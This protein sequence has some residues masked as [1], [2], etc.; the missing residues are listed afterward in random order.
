MVSSYNAWSKT[1]TKL[2]KFGSLGTVGIDPTNTLDAIADAQ[3]KVA[4]SKLKTDIF[5]CLFS[6]NDHV[7][8]EN[9]FFFKGDER[10]FES[11]FLSLGM[12]TSQMRELANSGVCGDLAGA[13]LR[14]A[15]EKDARDKAIY[16]RY[17]ENMAKEQKERDELSLWA[18]SIVRDCDLCD[19]YHISHTNFGV[20]V[21]FRMDRDR[22]I[23]VSDHDCNY[24]GRRHHA[25]FSL[26][27]CIKDDSLLRKL[28]CS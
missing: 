12:T 18:Q 25:Y 2:T 19:S 16:A 9:I 14:I 5:I 1:K 11:I 3:V 13:I 4:T 27:D 24:E 10:K 26:R 23:R 20:S 28:L 7:G 8:R 6:N 15:D 22:V 17:R 21:Y